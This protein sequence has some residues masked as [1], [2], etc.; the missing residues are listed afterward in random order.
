MAILVTLLAGL[1]FFVGYLITLIF[2]KQKKLLIFSVGFAFSIIFG[3]VI[4]HMIPESFELVSNKLLLVLFVLVGVIILKLLDKFVPDH[5]HSHKSDHME[6]IGIISALALILH[7]VIEGTAIYT[8]ALSDVN[9]GLVMALGV[10]FHNIPL[11]I[12]ISSLIKDKKSKL[13]MIVLLV[14]SCLFG[15]ILINVFGL[16]IDVMLK[17]ILIC[18]TIGMLLYI[19]FAELYCEVK[20]HIKDKELYYGLICGL[21]IIVISHLFH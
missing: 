2:K 16:V 11:G 21:I 3:L 13:F 1:S 7:N 17:G 18:I 5:H 20:E 8:T 9:M 15:V 12:Q 19:L 14:L 6:H 4:L 10:S